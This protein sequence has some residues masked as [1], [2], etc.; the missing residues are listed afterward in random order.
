MMWLRNLDGVDEY[1][2]LLLIYD[3]YSE[4]E[5]SGNEYINYEYI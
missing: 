3:E 1:V 5:F 4:D 2:K